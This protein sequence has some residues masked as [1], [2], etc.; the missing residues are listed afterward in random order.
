MKFFRPYWII[1][2]L[3][4]SGGVTTPAWSQH[5]DTLILKAE[6][7]IR[8]DSN[9]FR[10]PTGV[11]TEAVIGRP[12]AAEKIDINSLSLNFST[13]LS[14]QKLELAI[15]LSN[16]KYQNF[17]YLSFVAHNYSA[18]WR[19]ALTP[20]LRGNLVSQ[21]QETLNSFADYQGFD[22]QNLRTNKNNRLDAMYDL[23][24]TWSVNAGLS[25]STQVNQQALNTT[26]DYS[27][28]T[29]ELGIR[30]SAA[31][32]SAVNYTLRN[33][34]GSYLER[35]LPS[36]SLMDDAFKQTD[37]EMRLHW[38]ITGKSTADLYANQIARTHPHYPQRDYS[39]R[40]AGVNF[41]WSLSGNTALA[42]NW[43]R[44]LSSYQTSYASY[45]QTDRVSVGQIWQLG[46]KTVVRARY[47]VAQIDFLG[48]PF[49]PLAT[50]RSDT[51]SAASLTFDWQPHQYITISTSL[52]NA[53]RKSSLAG[54]DYESKMATVSAQFSY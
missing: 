51:T 46:A 52:E 47:E 26:E 25:K 34:S 38:V 17:N 6:T 39:G 15:N 44:E 33:A 43:S 1:L 53:S 32:G 50:R 37:S 18:A 16:Y 12:S 5:S 49:G 20:K 3:L 11:N 10:L 31:S 36:P 45:T 35:I 29:A 27:A 14:L 9:L 28:S 42:A 40:S 23:D 21:R 8:S 41:N 48:S 54:L 13:S 30:F 22:Q 4:S 24:G 2:G 19:W 7:S